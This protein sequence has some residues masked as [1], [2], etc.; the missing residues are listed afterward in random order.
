[1]ADL[2]FELALILGISTVLAFIARAI[3]QP[4]IIAYLI[5]GVVCGPLFFDLIKSGDVIEMLARIG[6]ALLLFIVGLNLDF[7]I[8]KEVG[9]VATLA[10]IGE[11]II[12]SII[13]FVIAMGL[14]FS[15]VPALYLAA[16]LAFSSTVI[17]VKLLSDKGEIDTLHGRIAIGILIIEDFVA[18]ILLM[19]IPVLG[20]YDVSIFGLQILKIVILVAGVFAIAYAVIPL[21]L[22]SVAK[23]QEVLFLFGLAWAL[24]VAVIFH[25]FGLS[26]EIGALLAGMALA[27]SKFSLEIAG[28]IKGLRDFF[29]VLFFVYIGSQLTGTISSKLILHAVIFS[30]FILVGK[31]IIVMFLMRSFGYKK[32]TNFF[33]GISLAQISEFSLILI[34]LGYT[35]GA[36]NQEL[37]SLILLVT[38]ITIILS[39]YSTYYSHNLFNRLSKLISLF[40]GS[41][42]EIG[43]NNKN[44]S[45]D[46]ILFGYNRV[47]YNLVK[48]FEKE[49]KSY[50]IIDYNPKTIIDL[51]RNGVNC[52]YG[53][54]NDIELLDELNLDKAKI[55]IST[56][57]SVE[58]NLTIL[59]RI[60]NKNVSFI[61]TSHFIPDSEILYE[62]GADYVIMPHF[63]G[64]AHTANLLVN[65]SYVK[66]K[67]VQE[68]KKHRKE[69]KEREELGHTHPGKESYGK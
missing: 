1:M 50:I 31:P 3:K 4:P 17:V 59:N 21:L 58:T 48:S 30:I 38:L 8:F 47:G 55:I 20:T 13:G 11:I 6:V 7:R 23:N 29:M 16:A 64:G 2:I 54:A 5:A 53:D 12:V 33:T 67:I 18:A 52:V 19:I 25:Y 37:L 32:R 66:N 26:L 51:A 45:Y 28:K 39:S 10:G 63:L 61:P 22:S 43:A 57:P 42:P 9:G 24:L 41:K 34:L 35:M 62:E 15:V 40:D 14:G 44:K 56:I 27:Q 36:V 65:S 46:I 68:G 69:L 60:K 49:K